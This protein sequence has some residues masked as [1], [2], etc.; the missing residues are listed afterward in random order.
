MI[1]VD[2]DDFSEDNAHLELLEEVREQVPQFRVT[3][4]TIPGRCSRGFLEMVGEKMPWVRMIP[5]GWS[6]HSNRECERWG[7]EDSLA[8]LRRMRHSYPCMGQGFKAPGWQISDGMYKA[9]LE[10]GY[11]VA[12]QQYNNY[13]R[14]PGLRAYLLDSSNKI[15]GHLGHLGGFNANELRTILPQ[16]LAAKEKPFGLVEDAVC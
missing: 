15:H 4:F 7:Y 10:M 11:W 13:R 2:L 12:D 6:H 14:P 8:Y 9:L 1:Y 16:I 5:H 3:L